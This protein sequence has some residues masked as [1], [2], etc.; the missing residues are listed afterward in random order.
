MRLLF[1]NQHYAPDI[2]ATGQ[3]LTDLA[4]YL[5][6]RG[7]DVHVLCSRGKYVAGA[8]DVPRE[9]RRNGVQVVR[10]GRASRGRSTHLGRLID[11]TAFYL[12]VLFHLLFGR[13]YDLVVVLTTPPLLSVATGMARRLRGQA[14]AIWSMDLHPDAEEAIGMAPAGGAL[15]RL[16]HAL[17]DFGYRHAAFVIA[18]GPFMRARILR[19]GV[20]PARVAIIPMWDRQEEVYPI[21]LEENAMADRVG[22]NGRCVVMYA[23]NAGLAHRFEEILEAMHR[24]RDHPRLFFLFAGDG[25]RKAEIISFAER[26]GLRSFRYLDYVPREELASFL[27]LGDIH[28]LTLRRE[29]AGIAVPSKL[30]GIFA[31]GRP[32]VMVGPTASEPGEAIRSAGA[33]RVIDPDRDPDP[34]GTLVAALETLAEDPCLRADQGARGRQTLVDQYER[35][36][37]CQQWSRL[38]G[39][40]V[41]DPVP[42]EL[43]EAV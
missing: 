30:Y 10:T 24:L 15:S 32:V 12:Q 13:R 42:A 11:Y 16:L 1:I 41:D 37:V 39:L 20:P 21:D 2:A 35:E 9:E 36:V 8:L 27:A 23:G 43:V 6:A 38:L 29:M 7:Q 14:Y 19:R 4:E 31:A 40:P 34:A 33:G 26:N 22:S 28:L 5:A 3:K 25:P 17:S 18:L